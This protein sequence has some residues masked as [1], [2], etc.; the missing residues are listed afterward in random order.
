VT[1]LCP[2]HEVV[3]HEVFGAVAPL[4]A[5]SP[6]ESARAPN[7]EGMLNLDPAKLLIIAVV[8]VILLGPDRLPQL[9]R[10]VG[11]YWRTFNDYRH[12]MEAQVRESMPDLPSTVEIT[13]LARSPSA[14]LDHLSTMGSD[15]DKDADPLTAPVVEP[16]PS[17]GEVHAVIR[18][19][20][21]P[22]AAR[23]VPSSPEPALP[24]DP[25][26]N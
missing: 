26:M 10:Q 3:V 22:A 24:G 5:K 11:G 12:R 14:L 1:L 19:A 13:R 20:H 25:A 16:S 2:V 23:P 4:D 6:S 7:K 21:R 9:A 8:A 15:S 17:D 18:P